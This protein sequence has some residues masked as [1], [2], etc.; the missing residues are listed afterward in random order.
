MRG[1]EMQWT[2]TGSSQLVRANSGS[3][4]FPTFLK[5]L[6]KG[7]N[8]ADMNRSHS[9]LAYW[10]KL[11]PE[12]KAAESLLFAEGYL[13]VNKKIARNKSYCMKHLFTAI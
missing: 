12:P 13:I 6:G 9:P 11:N 3:Y 5:S 1:L 2:E 8:Q 7:R 4:S 10:F